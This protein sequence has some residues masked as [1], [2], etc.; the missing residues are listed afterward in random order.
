MSAAKKTDA[1]MPLWIGAYLADTMHLSCEEHGAYLLLIMAYWRN[2][3]PL[4]DDDA[5]LSGITKSSPKVWGKLRKT[6]S[7][8]FEVSDGFWAHK[9]I[10]EELVSA[11]AN[12]VQK[13]IAGKASAAK[14]WGN[15]PADPDGKSVTAVK[16]PL[17]DPS[18]RQ[19]NPTPTPSPTPISVVESSETHTVV[20]SEQGASACLTA[21]EVCK[22]VIQL[23][24]SPTTC[25]PGHPDLAALLSAGAG[26]A[27]FEGAAKVCMEKGKGFPYLL[28]IVRGQREQAA[29]LVL[30]KGAL[31]NKQEAI[32]QSNAAATSGWKP[33]E[34][35]EVAD[36]NQ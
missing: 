15:K 18:Q 2:G 30:H 17:P 20:Y 14:R 4:P 28:G 13:S 21:G 3:G 12:K 16:E 34:M 26:M 32:E 27:E 29:K 23:G 5:R 9:R 10:D 25:N 35:R 7:Q 11:S 1:W 24:I 33:P 6:I 22:R 31:P 8:F 19:S 36:A